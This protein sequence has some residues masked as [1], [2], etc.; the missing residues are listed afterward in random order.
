M[1]VLRTYRT[2]DVVGLRKVVASPARGFT[3]ESEQGER[4]SPQGQ[5]VPPPNHN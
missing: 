3:R 4:P 5:I 2:S 1:S